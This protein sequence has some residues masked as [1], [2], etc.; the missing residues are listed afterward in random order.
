MSLGFNDR[1]SNRNTAVTLDE[2]EGTTILETNYWESE[3]ADRGI[4]YTTARQGVLRLLL[5]RQY[6]NHLADMNAARHV[7]LSRGAWPEG[8]LS[9]ALEL[10]WDD[11]SRAPLVPEPSARDTAC[12]RMRRAAITSKNA[13]C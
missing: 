9:D 5:P 7:I 13:S 1:N 6:W 8:R 2:D 12:R 10:M 11:E 3:L 4:I